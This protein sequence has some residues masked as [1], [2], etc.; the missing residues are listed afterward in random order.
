MKDESKHCYGCKYYEPYYTKGYTQFDRCDIG[1]CTKKKAT[2]ERHEICEKYDCAHYGRIHRR[3]A[4]L[5]A[6][7]EHINVL[8]ELKQIIEED[9]EDAIQELFL[10]FKNRKR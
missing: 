6:I 5:S 3:Q 2:V 1:F 8:S 7:A 9:D 10:N 4:A